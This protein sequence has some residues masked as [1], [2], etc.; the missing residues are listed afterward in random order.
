VQVLQDSPE[1]RIRDGFLP[2]PTGQGL[3]ATLDA[4][5]LAPFLWSRCEA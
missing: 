1:D 4:G 5:R 3:G 2:V